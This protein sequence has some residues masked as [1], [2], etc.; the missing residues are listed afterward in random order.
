MT[1]SVFHRGYGIDINL[2]LP[3]L[4]H[5]DRPGLLKEIY[6]DYRPDLLYC[7]G[8]HEYNTTCP[9]FMSVVHRNGRY[10]A[11]HVNYGEREE[12]ANESD[13][14]RALKHHTAETARNEGFNVSV[15]DR[16]RHGRRRTDVTIGGPGKK[17]PATKSRSQPSPQAP[18]TAGHASPWETASPRCGLSPTKTPSPSTGPPG[19]A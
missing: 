3:D 1:H 5:P 13:L 7:L 10:Y 17:R 19:R 15:E 12:T 16:A 6:C 14:H 18:W 8:A 9:G 4:G 2:S 11:R